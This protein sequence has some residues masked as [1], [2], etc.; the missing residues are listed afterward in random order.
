MR[1]GLTPDFDFTAQFVLTVDDLFL[2][3][4]ATSVLAIEVFQSLGVECALVARTDAP[5]RE[6]L[7][8]RGKGR[9][10]KHAQLYSV[11]EPAGASGAPQVVGTLIYEMRMRK[12]I[13][14]AVH[15]F[16][17]RFPDVATLALMPVRPGARTSEA[18][19]IIHKASGLR[20]RAG[21]AGPPAPYVHFEF[22]EFGEHETI[23][24]EGSAPSYGQEFRFPVERDGDFTEYLKQAKL[25]LNVFDENEEDTE[26]MLGYAELGL[27][28]LLTN[29]KLEVRELPLLDTRGGP[30]GYLHI[31]VELRE[32]RQPK[33]I[34]LGGA[35]ASLGAGATDAAAATIQARVRGRAAR[36]G[37]GVGLS[38]EAAVPLS[39]GVKSLKLSDDALRTPGL[40]AVWVEV[41]VLGLAKDKL[42]TARVQPRAQCDLRFEHSLQ[43][44]SSSAEAD[45]I[46]RALESSSAQVRS[47]AALLRALVI[48]SESF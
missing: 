20:V 12:R 21:G 48:P 8:M 27:T 4:A 17:Q 11:S 44:K 16:M 46:R 13:D 26:A 31:S 37:G 47:R 23:A 22:F 29:A 39:I 38:V 1:Q 34:S 6:L 42:R 25:R 19:V 18:I 32:A 14:A 15:S 2:H 9:L 28:P 45:A 36:R 7:Q 40:G 41:D 10:V 3:Y 35:T 30:A 43:V 5:L 33:P 24:K